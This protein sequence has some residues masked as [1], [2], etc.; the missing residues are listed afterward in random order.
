MFTADNGAIDLSRL[1][2]KV[3]TVSSHVL[4]TPPMVRKYIKRLNSNSSPGPDGIPAEF[5]K[6]ILCT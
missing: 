3:D 5:Y 2:D 1:P 4:F 6:V